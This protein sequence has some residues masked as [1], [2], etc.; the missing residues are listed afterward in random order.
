MVKARYDSVFILAMFPD[1]PNQHAELGFRVSSRHLSRVKLLV[2]NW[3]LPA[4]SRVCLP[5]FAGHA[6][7]EMLQQVLILR[8]VAVG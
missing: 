5:I 6:M 1:N 8:D 4:R 7:D 2:Q 3:Y